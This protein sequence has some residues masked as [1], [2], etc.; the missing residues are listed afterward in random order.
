[1]LECLYH[2][3][4]EYSGEKRAWRHTQ[5]TLR[6]THFA[7]TI[8]MEDMPHCEHAANMELDEAVI[9]NAGYI[10]RQNIRYYR[11]RMRF[12]GKEVNSKIPPIHV[13]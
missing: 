1:M 9:L 6:S 7:M 2:D 8:S 11:H 10:H 3:F 13:H 12:N 4:Y 5:E